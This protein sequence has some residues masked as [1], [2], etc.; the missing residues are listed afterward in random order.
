MK[1]SEN[2]VSLPNGVKDFED[3]EERLSRVK[4]VPRWEKVAG[5]LEIKE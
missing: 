5:M 3:S 2:F 1:G 4:L